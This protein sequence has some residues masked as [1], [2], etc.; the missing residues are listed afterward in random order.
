MSE[1]ELKAWEAGRKM[2]AEAFSRN[3]K[4][5]PCLDVNVEAWLTANPGG[6]T[7]AMLKGWHRGWA[8]ACVAAPVVEA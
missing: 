1:A 2:G 5:A 8:E 3:V 7:V 4:A 6:E